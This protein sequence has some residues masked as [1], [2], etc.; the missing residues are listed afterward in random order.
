MNFLK[1][2]SGRKDCEST[3]DGE[4][5]PRIKLPEVSFKSKVVFKSFVDYDIDSFLG[6]R[7]ISCAERMRELDMFRFH[8]PTEAERETVHLST[9]RLSLH[10]SKDLLALCGGLLGVRFETEELH[11]L[12]DIA[13]RLS[14]LYERLSFIF[15]NFHLSLKKFRIDSVPS[16]TCESTKAVM[17]F[18]NL[19]DEY[20]T[21][22]K[23]LQSI[24]RR[25]QATIDRD[26]HCNQIDPDAD[27]IVAHKYPRWFLILKERYNREVLEKAV[28]SNG[29][30]P[31]FTLGKFAVY[32]AIHAPERES[33]RHEEIEA[34]EE[35]ICYQFAPCDLRL[36]A[37][38]CSWWMRVGISML[39]LDHRMG[40]FPITIYIK[41]PASTLVVDIITSFDLFQSLS[42]FHTMKRPWKPCFIGDD[43]TM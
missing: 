23:D 40:S 27:G 25:K 20:L 35:V 6:H 5:G 39:S 38:L 2:I 1:E 41:N 31:K 3:P 26:A 43:V 15:T 28:D 34:L 18:H 42:Q 17:E 10:T 9:S 30:T 37:F 16:E 33:W 12:N 19:G 7:S 14:E 4:Q 22:V 13:H 24:I 8:N 21:L 11:Q 36:I 29:K 32:L